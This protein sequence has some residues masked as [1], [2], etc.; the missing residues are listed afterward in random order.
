MDERLR[1]LRAMIHDVAE[2]LLVAHE[3]YEVHIYTW[4][5]H[6]RPNPEYTGHAMWGMSETARVVAD[7]CL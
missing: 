6:E 7:F 4:L 3:V 2:R 5:D 1:A